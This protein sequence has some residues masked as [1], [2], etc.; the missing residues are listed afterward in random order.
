MAITGGIYFGG[1]YILNQIKESQRKR[2]I[3]DN[4]ANPDLQASTI[5]YKALGFN[6]I[7]LGVFL[8]TIEFSLFTNETELLKIANKVTNI[9]NV[10]I[11]YQKIY[12]RNLLDDVQKGF[13]TSELNAFWQRLNQGTVNTDTTVYAICSKVY[14]A[15]KSDNLQINSAEKD[16]KNKWFGTNKLYGN[17]SNQDYLG[18]VV[19]TGIYVN[20]DNANDVNNNKRYYIIEE[21]RPT[22]CLFNCNYG[23]VLQFQITNKEF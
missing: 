2:F 10:A 17:F 16:E 19:S 13:N 20:P 12:D 9:K 18:E 23:V 5:I 4:F 3:N 7:D 6:E 22:Q 11:I 15:V 21:T 14:S 8:P 1:K